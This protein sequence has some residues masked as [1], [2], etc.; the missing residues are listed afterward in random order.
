MFSFFCRVSVRTNPLSQEVDDADLLVASIGMDDDELRLVLEDV[1]GVPLGLDSL[2]QGL[3]S[4]AGS[5]QQQQDGAGSARRE[6]LKKLY[7]I[8]EDE[9]AMNS[10]E[11]C[12]VM[13]MAVKDH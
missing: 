12:V 8:T 13:R 11:D 1:K 10:L 9:L 7:K 5:Q 6:R 4:A 2:G 3:R